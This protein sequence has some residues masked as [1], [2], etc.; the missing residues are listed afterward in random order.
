MST[1]EAAVKERDGVTSAERARALEETFLERF[2]ARFDDV[3]SV[4]SPYHGRSFAA[5]PRERTVV[6][7]DRASSVINL[8]KKAR[9]FERSLLDVLPLD[10]SVEIEV[11]TR[12][13][14]LRR[15]PRVVFRAMSV[16]PLEDLIKS[17]E[18]KRALGPGDL[19]RALDE[20]VLKDDVMYFVGVLAT[21]GW[22]ADAVSHVPSQSNLA[23]CL[24]ENVG[25]TAWRKL[26]AIGPSWEDADDFF[27]PESKE[28][29]LS[30]VC[31]FIK[32]NPKLR[33]RGGFLVMR[34]LRED[35][36][37]DEGMLQRAIDEITSVDSD[38]ELIQAGGE[39]IIRR[40]RF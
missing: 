29:K 12:S 40:K 28:E 34:R 37:V 26:G 36:G 10:R 25:G 2:T 31:Q 4:W 35:L 6:R 16:S 11:F 23:V 9:I 24:V 19:E 38:L 1:R 8:M 22:T 7:R 17:R 21:P 20:L 32:D 5:S 33:P 30:R 14:F 15:E 13:F 18:S 3:R 39:E 27:D